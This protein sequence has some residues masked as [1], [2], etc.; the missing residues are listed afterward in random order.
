MVRKYREML[1]YA[2]SFRDL[3]V[4][5]KTRWVTREIFSVS[6][7]FPGAEKYALTDQVRRSS[8]AIGAQIAE[9]WA[10]RRYQKH[11]ISKLVDADSER[12]ETEHWLEIAEEC[13]YL[14]PEQV[15]VLITE[16][17]EIGRMLSSMITK[18]HSFCGQGPDRVGE[19]SAAYFP[20]SV[21]RSQIFLTTAS[22]AGGRG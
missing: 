7:A 21:H 2:D 20:L 10:K 3:V 18:A 8:R 11:F 4:Y 15:E 1:V 14:K 6:Q 9:A 12:L 22:F 5:Q 16:L 13:G 19:R 17:S